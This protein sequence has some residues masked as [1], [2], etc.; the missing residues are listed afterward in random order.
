MSFGAIR[1]RAPA[2]TANLGP[3]FDCAAVALDLWNELEV[4]PG[5]EPDRTHL[6]VQAFERLAPAGGL[7]FDFIDRIP[8][9][10][11]LGSS[12]AVIALGLVAGALA[13]G[14]D[15]VPQDLLAEGISLE[16]HAD[17]L[18]AALTGGAVLT[19]GTTIERIADDVPAEPVALVPE[20]RVG[21]AAARAALPAEIPHSDAAFSAGRAALLGAALA[22]GSPGLFAAALADRLHEPY[23]ATGAPLFA[24]V[25]EDLPAQALGATISGSGP[26]VIV[27]ARKGEAD[28]VAAELA[29][30]FPDVRVFWLK[31]SAEG[32][33]HA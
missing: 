3:G 29:D 19:W 15:L 28:G 1:V 17:N 30:R 9:E 18:A 6:G 23:R 22:S 32:A 8:R 12:A 25:R 5:G 2:T 16:G 24:E 21:T 27:W 31:V 11:G 13:A 10:R 33:G 14:R 26:T 4:T 7:R 20:T